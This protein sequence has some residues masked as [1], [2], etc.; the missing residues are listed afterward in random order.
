MLAWFPKA[1]KRQP[2]FFFFCVFFLPAI[3]SSN[4]WAARAEPFTIYTF[5]HPTP[6]MHPLP[7][8]LAFRNTLPQT[9]P[10]EKLGKNM[11]SASQT[12]RKEITNFASFAHSVQLCSALH[13]RIGEFDQHNHSKITSIFFVR[14]VQ[15][16]PILLKHA[17]ATSPPPSEPYSYY[18][19]SIKSKAC[20]LVS[21][22]SYFF[23]LLLF[24][25]LPSSHQMIFTY[26]PPSDL[27]FRKIALR[28]SLI[29]R[30]R[31]SSLS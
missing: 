14:L 12:L 30:G 31:S 13:V 24:P 4:P 5:T 1:W 7:Q 19:Q 25:N 9:L 17:A 27:E 16:C 15:I 28:L 3:F 11:N 18:F 10:E 8:A 2:R 29:C 26:S 22:L 21:P 23:S 6:W 20:P